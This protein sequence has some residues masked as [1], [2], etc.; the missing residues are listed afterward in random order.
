[1]NKIILE[2]SEDKIACTKKTLVLSRLGWTKTSKID[3]VKKKLDKDNFDTRTLDCK[4]EGIVYFYKSK[5][6]STTTTTLPSSSTTTTTT[7]S[8]TPSPGTY[9]QECYGPKYQKG[10]KDP[11]ATKKRPNTD[12]SIYQVQGCI[13]ATQDSYF[14]PKTL[15]ALKEKTGKNY[16]TD[17]DVD[18][19]CEGSSIDN[20]QIMDTPQEQIS[21]WKKLI[22]DKRIY[23]YG[24]IAQL[25][26]N[27][28]VYII[29][30]DVVKGKNGDIVSE[31]RIKLN[32]DAPVKGQITKEMI[33]NPEKEF[34][35]HFVI[36]PNENEGKWSRFVIRDKYGEEV[37]DLEPTDSSRT[38]E[39]DDALYGVDD[40]LES[41]VKREIKKK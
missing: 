38:W 28:V 35:V 2:T 19:I 30:Y 36:Q 41:Y 3:Y 40:I 17:N 25:K 32:P 5:G 27:Q 6:S 24:L 1:M 10:C 21:Y 15:K 31:K 11:G 34:I 12:G 26:S 33:K 39:P 14:G 4:T 16:F 13:G 22:K 9:Y 20:N 37:V 29:G 7:G 8:V 23:P 18:K